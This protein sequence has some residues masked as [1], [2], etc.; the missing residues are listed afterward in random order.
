MVRAQA[1]ILFVKKED[2]NLLK[3]FYAKLIGKV[4]FI[5]TNGRRLHRCH[6]ASD[7]TLAVKLALPFAED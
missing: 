1:L 3:N 4:T 5:M 2:F 6:K 7:W